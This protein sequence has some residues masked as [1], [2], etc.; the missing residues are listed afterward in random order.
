MEEEYASHLENQI[1][2]QVVRELV[3]EF[4]KRVSPKFESE[5]VDLAELKTSAEGITACLRLE[6]AG[7]RVKILWQNLG[8]H[9]GERHVQNSQIWMS[10]FCGL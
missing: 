5:K 8:I 9:S 1:Q 10:N 6:Y 3:M 7:I 2:E 4:L